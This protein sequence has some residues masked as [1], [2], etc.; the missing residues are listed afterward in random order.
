M[1]EYKVDDVVY[2]VDREIERAVIKRWLEK[3]F[4]STL[5][6]SAFIIGFLLGVIA[7][8]L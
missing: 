6:C 8:A 5:V 7:Y 2:E 1:T 3:R 4:L